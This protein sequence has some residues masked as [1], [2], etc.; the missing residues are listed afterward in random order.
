[1]AQYKRV[2]MRLWASLK[3]RF[4][5]ILNLAMIGYVIRLEVGGFWELVF[6][7]QAASLISGIIQDVYSPNRVKARAIIVTAPGTVIQNNNLEEPIVIPSSAKGVR[8]GT[9]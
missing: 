5:Q 4:Y 1:M 6:V 7:L 9:R 3:S 2:A 8:Y